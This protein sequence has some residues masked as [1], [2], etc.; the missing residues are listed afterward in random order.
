MMLIP[1]TI[2][3]VRTHE[4]ALKSPTAE[5]IVYSYIAVMLFI[6]IFT[7]IAYVKAKIQ[8]GLMKICLVVNS[9]YMAAGIGLFFLGIAS[10]KP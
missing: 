7:L 2:L 5:I 6:G 3:P 10:L 1:W 9:L 8:N 4:W